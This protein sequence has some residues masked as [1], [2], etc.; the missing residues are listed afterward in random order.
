MPRAR[1]PRAGSMQFWPRVRSRKPIPR[2]RNWQITKD[3]RPLGFAGYKVAMTHL[4]INDNMPNSLTKGTDIFC[5]VTIVECPPIKTS[6]I[7][8]YKKTIDGSKL[9]SQLFADSFDKELQRK[10]IQHKKKGKEAADFLIE[11]LASKAPID[12]HMEDQLLPFMAI[13]THTESKIIAPKLTNHTKTNIWV[14]E[15]FLPVKFEIYEKTIKCCK[16]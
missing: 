11:Q 9:V 13:C 15:K 6:S 3:A 8:F 16:L 14:I 10:M 5:P 4:M 7:M 1:K 12:E 2:I